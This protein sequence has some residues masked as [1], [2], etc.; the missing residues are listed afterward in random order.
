[1][2]FLFF[3]TAVKVVF[4]VCTSNA[5]QNTLLK[6]QRKNL[7]ISQDQARPPIYNPEDYAVALK[8]FTK[9]TPPP[10]ETCDNADTNGDING[11]GEMSLRQFSSASEL[12]NKLK[13]DLRVAYP[14]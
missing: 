2:G 9:R 12:L 6:Y 7:C 11:G 14:R 13:T 4:N 10:S 5:L 8:K 1:V 3:F